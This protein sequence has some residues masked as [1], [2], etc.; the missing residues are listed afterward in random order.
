MPEV[1]DC[2]V[3][4]VDPGSVLMSSRLVHSTLSPRF[5]HRV[6]TALLVIAIALA[7]AAPSLSRA[8][9]AV[10]ELEDP[11]VDGRGRR[12][13]DLQWA[14][15]ERALA[16]LGLAASD[17]P[18]GWRICALHVVTEDVFAADEASTAWLS[19]LNAMHST[20]REATV[21]R[22]LTFTEGDLWREIDVL[23]SERELDSRGLFS[24]VAIVPV[25]DP[26]EGCIGA[27]VLVR[28]RW[29]LYPILDLQLAGNTVTHLSISLIESNLLGRNISLGADFYRNPGGFSIGSGIA[30]PALGSRRLRLQQGLRAYLGRDGRLEGTSSSFSV[31]RPLRSV[32][33]R[34]GWRADAGHWHYIERKFVAGDLRRVE[35]Q[36]P[37]G[38]WV[39]PEQ[40][41]RTGFSVDGRYTFSL[42]GDIRHNLSP[43]AFF[44]LDEIRLLDMDSAG[45]PPEVV[46]TFLREWTP[47]GG[48]AVGP[49][50]SWSMY[51][52]RILRLQN[53]ER[54][55]VM[56]ETRLGWYASAGLS[57]SEPGLGASRRYVGSSASLG[58]T[59]ALGEDAWVRMGV[60]GY[61]NREKE[62]EILRT[63]ASLRAVSPEAFAGRV[64]LSMR[65]TLYWRTPL[66]APA[67]VGAYSPLRGR[68]DGWLRTQDVGL[69]NLEWRSISM[70]LFGGR[71][72]AAV[73][74]DTVVA[75]GGD[76]GDRWQAWSAAGIGARIWFPQFMQSI[77][78]ADLAM[79]LDGTGR[80][81][82][83]TMSMG[84][85]F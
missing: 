58:R 47:R 2:N 19:W 23:D 54:F 25:E 11:L 67:V 6:P 44:R 5:T 83:L 26:R 39:L 43:G 46:E 38:L 68:P 37:E 22:A 71:L 59:M 60:S 79:P 81:P 64:H 18:E 36:E 80:D 30:L 48:R 69:V 32:S 65:W 74:S 21:R 84:Q 73:F 52:E 24:V 56:E 10:S 45:V 13:G 9:T 27:L 20:T 63:G 16:A 78:R 29:S 53:V 33:D 72:G 28:D 66:K 75:R 15:V 3:A 76:I 40:W 31:A 35:I 82:Q 41:R 4:G 50:V 17:D 14:R 85:A 62:N 55:G 61:S 8:E 42:G 77:W 57:A 34:R 49:Q 51:E 7:A 1:L 70:R 12:L